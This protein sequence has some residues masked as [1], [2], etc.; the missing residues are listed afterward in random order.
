M[1]N[2]KVS[3]LRNTVFGLRREHNEF[4]DIQSEP[5]VIKSNFILSEDE[6]RLEEKKIENDCHYDN[7]VNLLLAI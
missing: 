6:I 5:L 7:T 1:T 2:D 4:G 3:G